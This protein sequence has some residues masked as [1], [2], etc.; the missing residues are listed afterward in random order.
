VLLAQKRGGTITHRQRHHQPFENKENMRL[1]FRLDLPPCHRLVFPPSDDSASK[2]RPFERR[3]TIAGRG[4]EDRRARS[5]APFHCQCFQRKTVPWPG[6]R[7]SSL[8]RRPLCG[9]ARDHFPSCSC[10]T[11]CSLRKTATAATS[12]AVWW[13]TGP[14]LPAAP[15]STS[16]LIPWRRA[17]S[18]SGRIAR[19]LSVEGVLPP[20]GS[21]SGRSPRPAANEHT[22]ARR[23][24]GP[25]H[26]RHVRCSAVRVAAERAP[27]AAS[28]LALIPN[29]L[30]PARQGEHRSA[31]RRS[32]TSRR[33]GMKF[34]VF[35]P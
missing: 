35:R 14:S 15:V 13:A 6:R 19:R 2:T 25:F 21:V 27:G 28:V 16:A 4:C 31:S 8:I 11:V 32:G 24:A 1:G 30:G 9:A 5:G 18:R 17:G 23:R 7:G 10:S 26:R 33:R 12:Y 20:R 29:G 22:A 34:I 3:H